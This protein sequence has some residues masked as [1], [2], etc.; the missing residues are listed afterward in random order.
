MFFSVTR[1]SQGVLRVSVC[2]R[3]DR[4]RIPQHLEVFT[5][6]APR[7]GLRRLTFHTG[8]GQ[9]PGSW[10]ERGP[11]LSL[12]TG[13]LQ[14]H[15]ADIAMNWRKVSCSGRFIKPP[16]WGPRFMS[17]PTVGAIVSC[18][19]TRQCKFFLIRVDHFQATAVL[20]CFQEVKL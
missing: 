10:Y 4:R 7:W 1:A 5:S 3:V 9:T 14:A 15:L 17:H 16:H 19:R 12:G 8:T 13:Y 6:C 18:S 20:R 2:G 11:L